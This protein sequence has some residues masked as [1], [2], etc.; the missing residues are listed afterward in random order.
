VKEGWCSM[1]GSR[2]EI[3]VIR[4]YR[5]GRQYWI[6]LEQAGFR[7]KVFRAID[8]ELCGS[9]W[10]VA[11]ITVFPQGEASSVHS[12]PGSEEMDVVLA[13][14]GE[15]V[16]GAGRRIKIGAH[17]VVFIPKGVEHQHVNT[18][19]EPLVLLWCYAPPGENPSR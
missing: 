8:R 15:V 10:L 5:E 19:D 14:S 17:D 7:R 11:G 13:G 1:G 4:P 12:H 9:E 2:E 18:G 3:R 6:G 16:D